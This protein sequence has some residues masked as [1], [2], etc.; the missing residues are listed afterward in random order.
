MTAPLLANFTGGEMLM[1]AAFALMFFGAKK[2]PDLMRGFGHAVREFKRITGSMQ[3][4]VRRALDEVQSELPKASDFTLD[5]H[6]EPH[7][8]GSGYPNSGSPEAQYTDPHHAGDYPNHPDYSDHPDPYH[9]PAHGTGTA[10]EMPAAG[11]GTPAT[12]DSNPAVQI[13]DALVPETPAA[14]AA[15]PRPDSRPPAAPA[16]AASNPAPTAPAPPAPAIPSPTPTVPVS[17]A[18]LPRV[19]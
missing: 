1:I 8:S 7:G 5:S 2:V 3:N 6:S 14:P 13:A 19:A 4:D 11:G 17:V 15:T 12:P 16:G 9:D 18:E 10:A